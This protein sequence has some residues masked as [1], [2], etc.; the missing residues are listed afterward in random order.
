VDFISCQIN[1]LLVGLGQE[2]QTEKPKLLRKCIESSRPKD[3]MLLL[4]RLGMDVEKQLDKVGLTFDLE[5]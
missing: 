1:H 5:A 4:A 2:V 3:A